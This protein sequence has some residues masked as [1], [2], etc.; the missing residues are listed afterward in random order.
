MDLQYFTCCSVRRNINITFPMISPQD[1]C[2]EIKWQWNTKLCVNVFLCR[3]LNYRKSA[4]TNVLEAIGAWEFTEEGCGLLAQGMQ[5]DN[6]LFS[7]I[8]EWKP[9]CYFIINFK[10]ELIFITCTINICDMKIRQESYPRSTMW[11]I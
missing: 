7:C 2:C 6:S 4:R 1:L 11:P 3:N 5:M 8:N 10:K 9:H